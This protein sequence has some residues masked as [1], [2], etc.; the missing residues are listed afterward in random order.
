M[1]LRIFAT[2]S[3]F[4]LRS[5]LYEVKDAFYTLIFSYYYY[6]G[7][8][9]KQQFYLSGSLEFVFKDYKIN[10]KQTLIKICLIVI[11]WNKIKKST[12]NVCKSFLQLCLKH[13]ILQEEGKK[14]KN[15]LVDICGIHND[16]GLS[17]ANWLK[18]LH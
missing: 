6:N 11:V 3:K 12:Y 13:N 9:A 2:V 17:T 5:I 18:A 4:D 10:I 15:V 14:I 1:Q 7:T 8:L 16:L